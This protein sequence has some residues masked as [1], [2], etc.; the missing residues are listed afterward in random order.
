MVLAP[1]AVAK[2]PPPKPSRT[3]VI[4]ALVT[5]KIEQ[6]TAARKVYDEET[7][8]LRVVAEELLLS[9]LAK[10]PFSKYESP[11]V[12]SV[13]SWGDKAIDNVTLK[14]DSKLLSKPLQQAIRAWDAHKSSDQKPE[15]RTGKSWPSESDVR[16][17]A[18]RE[19][20]QAMSA[21]EGTNKD[22]VA[23]MLGDKTVRTAF[24][25]MLA[26]LEG[27]TV[28]ETEAKTIEA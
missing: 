9:E 11:T 20:Q 10:T 18:R 2:V 14:L 17:A 1:K 27:K 22:R 23:S 28:T 6:V 24:E 12:P 26:V 8:R 25:N 16:N 5:L 21:K 7:E 3:Q 4:E 15:I 13:S 19:I